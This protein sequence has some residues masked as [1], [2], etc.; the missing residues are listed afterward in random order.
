VSSNETKETPSPSDPI[1]DGR[2]FWRVHRSHLVA[3]QA[4]KSLREHDDE[5][6]LIVVLA[7]GTE[8]VASRTASRRLREL[9]A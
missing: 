3:A 9:I 1:L 7:D 8:I 2:R 5:R 6:R 4:V